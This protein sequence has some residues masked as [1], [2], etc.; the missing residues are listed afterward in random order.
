MTHPL[1]W[2]EPC[3]NPSCVRTGPHDRC[4]SSL[5]RVMYDDTYATGGI[6]RSA[7]SG[8]LPGSRYTYPHPSTAEKALV[9]GGSANGKTIT[10][11]PA[12][13]LVS[14]AT[15]SATATVSPSAADEYTSS[16]P[17]PETYTLEHFAIYDFAADVTHTFPAYVFP[18]TDKDKAS[19]FVH[20]EW[21]AGRLSPIRT[22][23][24]MHRR[25][26]PTT[27]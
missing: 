3:P 27:F 15:Y 12:S 6:V 10:Y 24:G 22:T 14:F 25:T 18:G 5:R 21:R 13:Y 2:D 1:A 9:I 16:L 23:Y 20:S 17:L 11:N 4:A 19:E 7:G 26:T 8:M